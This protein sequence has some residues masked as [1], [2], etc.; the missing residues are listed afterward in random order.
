[1]H[2]QN[3]QTGKELDA[4]KIHGDSVADLQMSVDG[5]HF[6]TASTDKSAKLV[7]TQSLE[8]RILLTLL[9]WTVYL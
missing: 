2:K 4:N 8:V 6:V 5:T 7:D 9:F 1:M 3:M